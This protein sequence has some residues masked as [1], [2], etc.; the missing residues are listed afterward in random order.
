MKTL[1]PSIYNA[2]AYIHLRTMWC[3]EE[4]QVSLSTNN[5]TFCSICLAARITFQPFTEQEKL[6]ID[7]KLLAIDR[8]LVLDIC[9]RKSKIDFANEINT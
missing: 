4:T 7:A 9:N 8:K 2:M 5:P 3:W 6:L 1:N